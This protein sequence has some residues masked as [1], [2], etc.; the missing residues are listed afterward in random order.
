MT[1]GGAR[2]WWVLFVLV[3]AGCDACSDS[4]M[5]TLV[6]ADGTIERDRAAAP[7]QWLPAAVGDVIHRDEAVRTRAEANVDLVLRDGARLHLGPETLLRFVVVDA[8]S[9]VRVETGLAELEA[10][11]SEVAFE[12]DFGL[13][14]LSRGGRA[15]V[16]R[17]KGGHTEVEVL[18]GRAEIESGTERARRLV[19]GQRESTA[20]D[21]GAVQLDAAVPEVDAEVPDAALIEQAALDVVMEVRRGLVQLRASGVRPTKLRAGMHTLVPG[22][23]L[24]FG[25]AA[26]VA[27]KRGDARIEVAGPAR[28]AVGEE[29]GPMLVAN[30][31]TYTVSSGND[32]AELAVQGGGVL[33]LPPGGRARV[34][35]SRGRSRVSV[36]RG[37]VE[38]RTQ[39]GEQRLRP[40]ESVSVDRQGRVV[41][42]YRAPEYAEVTMVAGESPVVHDGRPPTAVRLRFKAPCKGGHARVEV[43]SGSRGRFRLRS[44]AK[45]SALIRVGAGKHRYRLRCDTDEGSK[46]FES[47]TIRVVRDAAVRKLAPSPPS[48]A[49]E[50]DG[51]R[52]TVF[53]QN[54]SPRIAMRWSRAPSAPSYKLVIQEAGKARSMDVAKAEHVFGSGQLKEGTHRFHFETAGGA[55]HRSPDTTLRIG[56]DNA[57]PAAYLN[58]RALLKADKA[59]RVALS[60]AALG[61]ARVRIGDKSVKTDENG[62]FWGRM[63]PPSGDR[64]V[65]VR[66]AHPRRGV[67]YYVRRLATSRR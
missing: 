25:R 24:K 51:R 2:Y 35:V 55:R 30:T 61:G 14:V 62:R 37:Q 19:A 3:C 60:G 4:A 8:R 32:P 38:V 49:I 54:R 16:R 34:Q 27:V 18:L 52:Y 26:R 22:A 56:F 31:G 40:G 17:A 7:E 13:A 41:D 44:R 12:T 15:R 33:A 53:Y 48:N 11:E 58:Q 23:M 20:R 9:R 36:E 64:G 67:H 28:F 5:A 43:A 47:G 50:A 6:K 39:R 29:P 66:I 45:N 65:A 10:L 59:G 63:V 46:A 42:G 21:A 57:S 1:P